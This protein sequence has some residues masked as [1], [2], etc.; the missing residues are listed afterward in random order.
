VQII[1]KDI[2]RFHAAFWPAILI[3][4]GLPLPKLLYVHGHINV[5]N[6]KMSKTIG[7]VIA[8]SEIIEKY[9]VDAYRY[10]FTRHVS[11][12]EDGDF[13]WKLMEA[14]YNNELANEL[15]N[16]VGRVASMVSQYQD[17]VVGEIP[18]AEH[19]IHEFR[20]A[21][22]DCRFDKALDEIWEQ[23]RGLNQY[24]DTEKPW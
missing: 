16:A 21:L 24:I 6:K 8:P 9:G 15:G 10:Y 2:I 22:A 3:A 1:G 4:L 13:T 23:V 18:S 20:Q 17:N 11:S 14:A 5:D 12:Y 7:N 19:D